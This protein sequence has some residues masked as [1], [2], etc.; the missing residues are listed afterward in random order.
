VTWDTVNVLAVP[1][2]R[3]IAGTLAGKILNVLWMDQV[4]ISQ[5]LCPFPCDVLVMYQPGKLA[6]IPSVG[7]LLPKP[8][9]FI[10]QLM[11]W[12]NVHFDSRFTFNGRKLT[13]GSQLDGDSCG[14]FTMNAIWNSIFNTGILVHQE[15]RS[16][17]IQ[18]F[19]RLCSEANV[20]VFSSVFPVDSSFDLQ[21]KN[22]M[23]MKTTQE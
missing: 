17:Q 1:Q 5:V 15:L 12:L 16:D 14:F 11:W 7:N 22:R 13:T 21:F 19:N 4:A 20:Q 2:A 8:A 18:W 9:E 23:M 6:L 3:E 10:E